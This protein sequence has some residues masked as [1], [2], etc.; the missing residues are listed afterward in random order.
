MP[1]AYSMQTYIYMVKK[2]A[3]AVALG[4]LGGAARVPKGFSSLTAEERKV[5]AVAAAR[6]RWDK[7]KPKA[8]KKAKKKAGNGSVEEMTAKLCALHDSFCVAAGHQK[9]L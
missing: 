9:I 2:N 6:A 8:K 3:A 1:I 7:T 4:R 5:N